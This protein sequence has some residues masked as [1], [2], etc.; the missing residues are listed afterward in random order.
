MRR[1]LLIP[2]DIGMGHQVRCGALAAELERRGWK[3]TTIGPDDEPARYAFDL[4]VVDMRGHGARF[5][6]IPKCVRIIDHPDA[7]DEAD[8]LVLGSAG[9]DNGVLLGLAGAEVLAGPRYS[10]LRRAFAEE[11]LTRRDRS[12]VVDVREIGGFDARGMA[13]EMAGAEVVVTYAGMRAM[14]AACVASPTVLVVR[15]HG[16][17]LNAKGLMA[18]GAAMESSAEE[19]IGVAEHMLKLRP[20]LERMSQHARV[21]VDGLGCQRVADAIEGLFL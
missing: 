20:L 8:L 21:F 11:R 16:E 7:K 18:A 10:L 17:R 6:E 19:A 3:T 14:E 15:N 12:G 9:A 5:P 4:V 13:E 1:A 2:D